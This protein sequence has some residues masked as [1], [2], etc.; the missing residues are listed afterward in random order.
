[1][2]VDGKHKPGSNRDREFADFKILTLQAQSG[3]LQVLEKLCFYAASHDFLPNLNNTTG[4]R[5]LNSLEISFFKDQN[6][7]QILKPLATAVEQGFL[8]AIESVTLCGGFNVENQSFRQRLSVANE[9]QR[10]RVKGVSVHFVT[11]DD[12]W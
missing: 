4:W 8:P 2:N 6:H 9:K 10:L 1:M 7:K 3:C 11:R 12:S 5:R